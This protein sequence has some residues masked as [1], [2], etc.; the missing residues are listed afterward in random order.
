MPSPF[1]SIFQTCAITFSFT[2]MTGPFSVKRDNWR[3]IEVTRD[4]TIGDGSY[5]RVYE[6]QRKSYTGKSR[7]WPAGPI[8][9]KFPRKP[10][11]RH[12][13]ELYFMR[14]VDMMAQVEHPACLSLFAWCWDP[15]IRECG[16][17]ATELMP[18]SLEEIIEKDKDGCAPPGWT[19]TRRSCVAFAIA[20]GMNHLHSK[21]IV[22]R[23][24]KPANV[25]LDAQ[26]LPRVADFGFAKFV[27]VENHLNMT[28]GI[29]SP[30]YMAPE[31][32]ERYDYTD[33]VDVYSYGIM[34]FEM[35]TSLTP[36]DELLDGHT[37]KSRGNRL[38]DLVADGWRPMCPDSLPL[39]VIEAIEACWDHEPE[40]RPSFAELLKNPDA[41]VLSGTDR[42]VFTDFMRMLLHDG[43]MDLPL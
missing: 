20:A 36:F 31:L 2:S 43:K 40:N 42:N 25:L 22:H 29:G 4:K 3:F 19:P 8:A 13:D 27:T 24:L 9:V 18:F 15:S 7:H 12:Q 21:G 14:E 33:K 37:E 26:L 34:L 32:R 1:L 6:C 28:S 35:F 10:F 41:F 30:L 23:D 11:E 5:G 39:K 38:N 16:G 17:I